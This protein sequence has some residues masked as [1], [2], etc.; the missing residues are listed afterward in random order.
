MCNLIVSVPDHC[1]S[2]TSNTL[3]P[4]RAMVWGIQSPLHLS[5]SFHS[6]NF[7]WN[8]SGTCGLWKFSSRL[9]EWGSGPRTFKYTLTT[10]PWHHSR[11]IKNLK[12]ERKYILSKYF[13]LFS[14]QKQIKLLATIFAYQSKDESKHTFFQIPSQT[15]PLLSFHS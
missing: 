1:L 5:G 2:S 8:W 15:S 14:I 7:S 3:M 11:C 9:T 12:T 6:F 10:Q 13:P 4:I